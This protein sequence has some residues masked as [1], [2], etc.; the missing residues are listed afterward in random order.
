MVFQNADRTN[1]IAVNA[2][3][4]FPGTYFIKEKIGQYK[5]NLANDF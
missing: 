2:L 3:I 4:L 5:S 1:K